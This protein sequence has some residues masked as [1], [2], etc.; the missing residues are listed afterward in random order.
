MRVKTITIHG[1]E[2]PI[3]FSTRV[4]V[5][6]EA[7]AGDADA[8]LNRIFSERKMTDVFWLL[9]Q[10]MDAGARYV[11]IEGQ[12]PPEPLSYDQLLDS[13]GVDDYPNLFASLSSTIREDSAPTVEAA[14]AKNAEATPDT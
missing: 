12:T 5:A 7:K 11:A 14:P 1:K 4:L 3:C 6:L 13:I 9:A 2:H 8:E 10:M